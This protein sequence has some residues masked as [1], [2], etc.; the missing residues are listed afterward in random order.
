MRM[1]DDGD[2]KHER[3]DAQRT[4]AKN[5]LRG[6]ITS[7]LVAFGAIGTT[8]LAAPQL[9]NLGKFKY[10]DPR[11]W[12]ALVCALFALGAAAFAVRIALKVAFTGYTEL[13]SLEPDDIE[14]V[15]KNSALL[16]GFADFK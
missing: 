4:Q 13:N 6:S 5:S 11:L 10:D 12:L 16:E 2:L 3:Y 8:V 14:Y 1:A 15:E 7:A 9:S